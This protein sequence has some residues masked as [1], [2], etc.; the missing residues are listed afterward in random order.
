MCSSDFIDLVNDKSVEFINRW[1]SRCKLVDI[2]L[3]EGDFV[4]VLYRWEG[5]ERIS[6][7][8]LAK[9]D[10]GCEPTFFGSLSD[11][12]ESIAYEE[13]PDGY[14]RRHSNEVYAKIR[15]VERRFRKRYGL[16][17]NY[18]WYKH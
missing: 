9:K 3:R 14:S 15:E 2:V 10:S 1:L 12:V 7:V 5:S 11:L 4:Y 8:S 18:F 13:V 16:P 17:D 6:V